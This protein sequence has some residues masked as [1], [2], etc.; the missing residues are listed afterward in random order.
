MVGYLKTFFDMTTSYLEIVERNGFLK[1]RNKR[2]ALCCSISFHFRS[3]IVRLTV[4]C[5]FPKGRKSDLTPLIL[6]LNR[7]DFDRMELSIS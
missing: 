4:L 5:E 7:L 6:D 3:K 1:T 2:L